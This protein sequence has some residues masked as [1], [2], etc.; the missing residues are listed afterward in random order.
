M[1][2]NQQASGAGTPGQLI[3]SPAQIRL[4]GPGDIPEIRRVARAAFYSTYINIITTD[5]IEYMQAVSYSEE[6]LKHV[7]EKGLQNFFV[8]EE[9]G[10]GKVLAFTAYGPQEDEP[11][12][13]KLH[14]L[15]ALAEAQGTGLGKALI[16]RV[17]A[18]V[19]ALGGR[20]LVLNV[21]RNNPAY[22]FYLK[23]GFKV[24][25]SVDIPFGPYWLNDYYMGLAI[26]S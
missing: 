13:Y 21:H 24:L 2:L 6:M 14:K 15:Y 25:Q 26:S 3:S 22:T 1:E 17:I 20:L 8:A 4:A 12:V 7:M 23:T 16:H 11:G 10:S 5:Q 18:E 9:P 19:K